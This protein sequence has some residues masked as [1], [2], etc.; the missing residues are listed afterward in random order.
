M[1]STKSTTGKSPYSSPVAGATPR[2]AYPYMDTR[3]I[4]MNLKTEVK[5]ISCNPM[6]SMY[7][8]YITIRTHS[9]IPDESVALIIRSI[10]KN[11]DPDTIHTVCNMDI[12]LEAM[13]DANHM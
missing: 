13:S 6:E 10:K 2:R 4:K 12:N 11:S 7:K 5:D 8:T 9:K 3:V 1:L